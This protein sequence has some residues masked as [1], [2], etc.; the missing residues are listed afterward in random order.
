[1][2]HSFETASCSTALMP[3][4]SACLL[5]LAAMWQ[6]LQLSSTLKLPTATWAHIVAVYSCTITCRKCVNLTFETD[7]HIR[8][9]AN[10][11]LSATRSAPALRQAASWVLRGT[12]QHPLSRVKTVTCRLP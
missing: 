3:V 8:K 9:C 7:V 12:G 4:A 10:W 11:R 6:R 5:V 2:W 1:M